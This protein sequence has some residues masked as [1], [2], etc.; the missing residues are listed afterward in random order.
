LRGI[1]RAFG[2]VRGELEDDPG[3]EA[4][5]ALQKHAK[6]LQELVCVTS[7]KPKLLLLCEIN[8]WAINLVPRSIPSHVAAMPTRSFSDS[9]ARLAIL[10]SA[11]T[12]RMFLTSC[13]MPAIVS[14]VRQ[15]AAVRARSVLQ[16]S[17]SW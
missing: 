12:A 14:R 17:A 7:L 10:R 15:A 4:G 2:D 9:F 8:N 13:A 11:M 3:S 16:R 6:S 5:G 1:S